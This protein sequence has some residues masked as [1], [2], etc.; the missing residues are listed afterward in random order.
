M[1]SMT[2]D[3]PAC[4][5]AGWLTL[6]LLTALAWL[7]VAHAEV[8]WLDK[9]V[10]IAGEQAITQ[11][12]LEREKKLIRQQLQARDAKI[13]SGAAFDRQILERLILKKLQ[14]Q[15]AKRAGIQI[16][17]ETLEK[18]LRK[19]AGDNGMDLSHFR[20]ALEKE[21]LDYVDFRNNIRD[22]LII[23][24]LHERKINRRIHVSEQ[25]VDD[26]I[27]ANLNEHSNL[28]YKLAHILV[29]VPGGATPEQVE[30][31][32]AKIK[33]LRQQIL[34][35]E[36]FSQL[37]IANSDGQHALKG[38]DL[39]WR[40]ASQLPTVFA[41]AV[42][43][44]K[45]GE[46][47]QPI[48]GPSGFHL[49]MVKE[50]RGDKNV[51]KSVES[52]ARHILITSDD[53]KEKLEKIRS[54]ILAGEDFAKLARR[55]SEDKGSAEQGG[56]LG[57]NFPGTFVPAFEAVLSKLKPGEISQPFKSRYGWHI[58][59]LEGRRDASVPMKVLRERARAVLTQQ[60]QEEDLQLWLQRLRDES[61]VENRLPE[62]QPAS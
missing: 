12:E 33:K 58:V 53:G 49:V 55:Y 39:G 56:D 20:L 22:E 3:A 41:N 46:V 10:A 19:I 34:L 59:Q 1:Y 51:A 43:K 17:D 15:A 14:L 37:A 18:A 16:D 29:A 38:G 21:G 28:E 54:R 9:I 44:L 52:H 45:P 30:Q 4:R 36:D 61:F 50:I 35:G 57:W 31:A 48:R 32:R 6:I 60:K 27:A 42:K 24:T 2:T 62:L 40:K 26:L 23:S 7:P 8:M 25:E 47:S 13:P 5:P 11:A